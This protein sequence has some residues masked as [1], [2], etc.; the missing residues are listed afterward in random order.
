MSCSARRRLRSC[1]SRPFGPSPPAAPPPPGRPVPRPRRPTPP[2]PPRPLGNHH[3]YPSGAGVQPEAVAGKAHR[4]A[5][6]L[7][8]VGPGR[9]PPRLLALHGRRT[10]LAKRRRHPL[11]P[12][13]DGRAGQ[14][15]LRTDPPLG[16]P[17]RRRPPDRRGRR[18]PCLALR[19]RRDHLDLHVPSGA[20]ARQAVDG[21]PCGF[22]P[23]GA[24][25]PQTANLKVGRCPSSSSPPNGG[26][27]ATARSGPRPSS[28]C[29]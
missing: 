18:P 28:G 25:V 8:P 2:R 29:G 11:R 15:A 13:A 14:A 1:S 24:A 23:P 5:H 22:H 10:H 16:P 9:G 21:G 6:A 17:A 4:A 27:P 19:R 26:R 20:G 3:E 12:D 7:R